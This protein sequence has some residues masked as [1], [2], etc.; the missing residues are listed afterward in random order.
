VDRRL[1]QRQPAGRLQ[2]RVAQRRGRGHR[3]G[4]QP[5]RSPHRSATALSGPARTTGEAAV[6]KQSDTTGVPHPLA[7]T[8]DLPRQVRPFGSLS[9]QKLPAN[10]NLRTPGGIEPLIAFHDSARRLDALHEMLVKGLLT[11]LRKQGAA[12]RLRPMCCSVRQQPALIPHEVPGSSRPLPVILA[13]PGSESPAL[14]WNPR[15]FR[16]GRKYH[17][18]PVTP[19]VA[20]SSRLL[21]L[22]SSPDAPHDEWAEVHC[23]DKPTATG[24]RARWRRLWGQLRGV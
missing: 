3:G 8:R 12:A 5:P 18:R 9:S 19:E 23:G 21:P 1:E 4:P 7:K 10:H 22:K 16:S 6:L 2:L 11:F 20:G 14:A 24:P 15:L 13:T 17:D